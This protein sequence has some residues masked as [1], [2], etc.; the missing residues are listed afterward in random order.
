M[1]DPFAGECLE[2]LSREECLALLATRQVGRLGVSIQA[3][4]AILPVNF[5][6]LNDR[7]IVRTV[8]GTK[9]DAAVARAVVA[10]EVDDYDPEGRWEWS[11]LVRGA[12]TEITEPDE[13]AQVKALPLRA[14]AFKNDDVT[15]FLAIDTTLVSGRRFGGLPEGLLVTRAS[16]NPMGWNTRLQI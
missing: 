10:F 11:V 16:K 7:I 5:R 6:L 15:R 3:L 8:H 2:T 1:M 4:P 13:L 14:R 12:G 9:L